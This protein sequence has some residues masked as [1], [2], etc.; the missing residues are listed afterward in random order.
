[1]RKINSRQIQSN[2]EN[3]DKIHVPSAS[4]GNCPANNTTELNKRRLPHA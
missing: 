4:V 1:M 3:S 2:V